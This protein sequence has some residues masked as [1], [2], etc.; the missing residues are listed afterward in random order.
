MNVPFV[1]LE[2]LN[3]FFDQNN[4]KLRNSLEYLFF[5]DLHLIVLAVKRVKT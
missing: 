4:D 1:I 3:D 2:T 5:K